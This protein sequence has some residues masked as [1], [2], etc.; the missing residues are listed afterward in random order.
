M[1]EKILVINLPFVKDFCRTQRWAART[2]GRVLRHPD[3]LAYT[4]AVLEQ[5]NYS[6]ELYDF[7]ALGWYKKELGEVIASKN[8]AVVVM[9]STTPSVYSDIEC[10]KIA[11]DVCPETKVIMVGPHISSLSEEVLI[12]AAGAIDVAARGEYE[13]TVRDA[14]KSLLNTKDI[15]T[16]EGISYYQQGR[17]THNPDRPLITDLDSLPF[18]AWHHLDMSK[19]FD[20]IKLY[21]YIDIIGGRGCPNRC[22]FCLWPQVMHGNK[23]RFRSPKNIVD[24]MEHSIKQFPFIKKG[25]FFFEDDTFTVNNQRAHQIC[26]EIMSRGLKVTWSINTRAD[27][28][29]AKLFKK[30]RKAGCRLLLVGYESGDQQ[31]LNNMHKNITVDKMLDFT[32]LANRSGLK[33]HGCFVFGLPGEDQ[34]SI[35]RTIDFALGL[36]LDTVQFS[37]AMPFPGTEYFRICDEA[38]LIH[39]KKWS[40]WLTGGE[41]GTPINYPHLTKDDLENSVNLALR[42]F[43]FRPNYL[44]RFA[45]DTRSL[46]DLYRK[47]RGAKNF[48]SYLLS[49]NQKNRNTDHI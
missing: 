34:H 24:E 2:R 45:L 7:P 31:M 28:L 1:A 9:D 37:A 16:V 32:D 29:D 43:Y 15:T 8:P 35:K 18:P 11:K 49:K 48:M 23:Y 3:W 40:D 10:A 19:Y 44:L 47:C 46:S 33:V 17:V 21:P 36:K 5:N 30:M 4:A 38:G 41:Q 42:K 25:E 27:V 6:V 14:V 20:G 39:S 13:Y 26:E 12:D 22:I